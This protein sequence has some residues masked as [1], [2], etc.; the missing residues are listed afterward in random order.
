[1]ELIRQFFATLVTLTD[2][3]IL[4]ILTALEQNDLITSAR[5]R[6]AIKKVE[7]LEYRRLKVALGYAVDELPL[8]VGNIP[9]MSDEEL[10]MAFLKATPDQRA[11]FIVALDEVTDENG[12][13]GRKVL[14]TVQ[15]RLNAEKAEAAKKAQEEQEMREAAAKAKAHK[16]KLEHPETF[17]ARGEKVD[18]PMAISFMEKRPWGRIERPEQAQG[19]MEDV[20]GTPMVRSMYT[21]VLIPVTEAWTLLRCFVAEETHIVR[22][23]KKLRALGIK[24]QCHPLISREQD[25]KVR[26]GLVEFLQQR[27][28]E[29]KEVEERENAFAEQVYAALE[30]A[31][32]SYESLA[33][34]YLDF[35]AS[36]V[37]G[38][39]VAEVPEWKLRII[40]SVAADLE[41]NLVHR[42]FV[43]MLRERFPNAESIPALETFIDEL[44]A[45]Y[46]VFSGPDKV[47]EKIK[48]KARV[49]ERHRAWLV[50]NPKGVQ[51]R[52]DRGVIPIARARAPR[53]EEQRIGTHAYT[54]GAPGSP[55]FTSHDDPEREEQRRRARREADRE[56]TRA[57]R[58]K[59]GDGGGKGGQKKA[60]GG[61]KGR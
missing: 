54:K 11:E 48:E 17:I 14:S 43:G 51:A 32:T 24:A 34:A 60:A 21:G 42:Q 12:E 49:A 57:T 58:G 31:A 52:E 23:Q 37:E 29:R 15:D 45:E 4:D 20:E 36:Q 18:D 25:G 8:N 6:A 27:E 61:K 9:Y 13:R 38:G 10:V 47:G 59:G 3:A 2:K 33:Q 39:Q 16:A 28:T 55:V 26:R 7:G 46:Q 35:C 44:K 19:L 40:D 5:L 56:R 30:P 50:E 53:K 1:M 41:Y 22:L